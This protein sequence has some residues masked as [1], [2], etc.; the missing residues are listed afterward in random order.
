MEHRR[1]VAEPLSEDGVLEQRL[2]A[3]QE[4]ER[5]DTR[6]GDMRQR[7]RRVR[8]EVNGLVA[9]VAAQALGA[10]PQEERQRR[11]IRGQAGDGL[12]AIVFRRVDDDESRSRTQQQDEVYER[13]GVHMAQG[14]YTD[15]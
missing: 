5:L 11:A 13:S 3:V 7:M 9:A 2:G 14:Y 12:G 6:A 10:G 15:G 1:D 8:R 4:V